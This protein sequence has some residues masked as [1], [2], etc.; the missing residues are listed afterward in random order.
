MPRPRSVRP[1]PATPALTVGGRPDGSDW[2]GRLAAFAGLSRSEAVA[3]GLILLARDVG[4]AEPAPPRVAPAL[5]PGTRVRCRDAAAPH[6]GLVGTVEPDHPGAL[7][8][9]VAWPLPGAQVERHPYRA[10]DLEPIG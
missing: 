9:W 8:T 7:L 2:V 1:Q 10:E 6:A 3:R 5:P 4:Y